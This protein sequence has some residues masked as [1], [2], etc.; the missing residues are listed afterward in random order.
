MWDFPFFDENVH[1]K[2]LYS[3]M[4]EDTYIAPVVASVNTVESTT[5]K[6]LFCSHL[7]AVNYFFKKFPIDQAIADMNYTILRYTQSANMTPMQY[8]DD[9]YS[10][11]CKVADIYE[12]STL[13]DNSIERFD[14]SFCHCLPN[15]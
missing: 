14:S 7:K 1:A 2:M 13:K 5:Q 8:E 11:S 15:Y 12:E 4:S 9:L 10:K 6:K 3:R